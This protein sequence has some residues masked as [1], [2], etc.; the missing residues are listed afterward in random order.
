MPTVFLGLGSNLGNR[1]D[2]IKEAVRLIQKHNISLKKFSS[3]IETEP[4]G[5]PSQEKFL[6]TVVK[7]KT[8][9]SARHLLKTLKSIEK[10][11]GRRKTVV[12]GPRIIDI[13]ILLY[14][15]LT[16][17]TPQLIIPHP[18]MWQRDFVMRPLKEIAP[19]FCGSGFVAGG[20]NRETRRHESRKKK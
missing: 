12:N 4:V 13:D 9:L 18:R 15:A 7:V 1:R 6:N 16:L 10:E 2:N 11:L 8:D 17:N 19:E 5:G 3:I 14:D 20:S